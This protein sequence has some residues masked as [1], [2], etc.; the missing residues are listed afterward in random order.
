[1]VTM[2]KTASLMFLYTETS[3]HAGSGTSLGVVDLPI[4]REKYTD[5]PVIQASGIKG[6]VREWFEFR[7]EDN[8]SRRKIELTFGP[9]KIG[10]EES[11]YAAAIT[12]TDAR[13]LLF[14]VRSLKA[15]FA[16]CT[17]PTV[18]ERFR[19][20]A[21]IAGVSSL[22]WAVPTLPNDKTVLGVQDGNDVADGDQVLLEEYAF[23]FQSNEQVSKIADWLAAHAFPAGEEYNFW[24][25]KIR[26]SLLV[27][28]DNAFRDFVKLSTEVQ[29]RIK[30]D[31]DKRTVT[32]GGLFY[33][34]ALLPDSLL[35]SVIL[36]H[37]PVKDD[38]AELPDDR[39]VIAFLR[40]LDGK[41]LQLGG[42]ATI[43]RGIVSVRFYSEEKKQGSS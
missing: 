22:S 11:G 39:A 27:L 25:G 6:A 2:F 43:G 34:E 37:D 18:L 32:K 26:K 41:R 21:Q 10:T 24:K 31:N 16:Y 9:D 17:S 29:A 19:R 38:R 7:F 28:P 8:G 1:M 33:E 42:D 35:Y 23:G 15:I 40:E 14:P 30:I 36:A 20:D 13:T 5:F 12:F 4:Q 3:L